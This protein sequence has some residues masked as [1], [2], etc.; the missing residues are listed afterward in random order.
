M[1]GSPRPPNDPMTP[2]LKEYNA[3]KDHYNF[4]ASQTKDQKTIDA[5][6]KDMEDAGRKV[7]GGSSG[8]AKTPWQILTGR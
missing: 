8:G 2:E 6:K 3:R 7:T 4:V 1:A 5:A